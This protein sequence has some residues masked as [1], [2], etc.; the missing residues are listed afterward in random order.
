MCYEF[1]RYQRPH[2]EEQA[3]KQEAAELI[4][5]VK[6]A[7]PVPAPDA[8]VGDAQEAEQETVPA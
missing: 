3:A 8:P 5:K 7:K 1:W 2:A 4:D 6:S